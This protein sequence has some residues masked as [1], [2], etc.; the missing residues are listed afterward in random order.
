MTPMRHPIVFSLALVAA[1]AVG[2]GQTVSIRTRSG[3]TVEGAV[4]AK[5]IQFAGRAVALKD[6]LSL[7]SAS[8]AS[9]AETERIAADLAAA[10]GT[11]K[12]ARDAAIAELVDIG[13]PVLT[14]L[15]KSYKDTAL[16]EPKDGA[17]YRIFRGTSSLG[18]RF[19]RLDRAVF[20][21]FFAVPSVFSVFSVF[22]GLA[23][24]G[25]SL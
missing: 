24:T 15:L 5:S 25:T 11:D 3:E 2:E 7:H 9:T 17:Y 1:S 16:A 22:S 18:Q 21:L 14:P 8:E 13:L 20:L 6:I 4:S 10:A 19:Q 12:S 23:S